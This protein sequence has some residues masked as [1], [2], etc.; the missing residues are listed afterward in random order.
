M[1]KSNN[2]RHGRTSADSTGPRQEGL[3]SRITK[4]AILAGALL[5]LL[6]LILPAGSGPGAARRTQCLNNLRNI[7]L[8]MTNYAS[9]RQGQL[10]YSVIPDSEGR[11]M[12]SWRVALLPYLDHQDLYLQYRF[13]EPWD[14][15]NNRRLHDLVVKYFHCPD[16]RDSPETDTSYCL[17]LGEGTAFPPEGG[18]TFDR[19]RDGD[20]LQQTLL[21]VEV[22]NSGIHWME[23]RDLHIREMSPT[24]NPSRGQGISSRHPGIARAAFASGSVR[25]LSA[26][27]PATTIRALLTVEGG[28]VIGDNG[29]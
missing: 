4:W 20:G 16:D 25:P 23:P 28:E 12:H 8:A 26:T 2:P 9:G 19:I 1:S 21:V 13:D 24:I 10:P 29:F 7:A 22:A 27:I 11:P 3:L 6:S 15:P 18:M 5:F 17:V 14:G